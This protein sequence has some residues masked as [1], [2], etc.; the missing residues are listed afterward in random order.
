MDYCQRQWAM[1]MRDTEREAFYDGLLSA[2]NKDGDDVGNE[3][4]EFGLKLERQEDGKY[5][6][7]KS[8]KLGS[9]YEPYLRNFSAVVA[10]RIPAREI[11]GASDQSI[12]TRENET[13]EKTPQHADTTSA[14]TKSTIRELS[15]S[16]HLRQTSL[17]PQAPPPLAF[18][19]Q[20]VHHIGYE[21]MTDRGTNTNGLMLASSNSD[22]LD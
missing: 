9:G 17:R 18:V 11:K 6:V 14:P 22:D 10:Q 15:Q 12:Y 21:Q 19:L 20:F 16:V 1:R 8:R 2:I 7:F 5:Q 3:L 4:Q 13:S